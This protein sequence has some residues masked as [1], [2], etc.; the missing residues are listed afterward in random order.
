MTAP[1][2]IE[3]TNWSGAVITAPSGESFSTISAEWVV[4]TVTQVPIK[5]VTTS[6][7]AEWVGIDGYNSADVCQ[8]GVLETVQTSA[9][10][11]ITIT[12]EAFVEW[13]PGA[14]II[15]PASSFAVSPGNTI[16]VTVETSGKGA[17]TATVIL[18]DV[19]TGQTDDVSLT[20]PKGTSLQGNSAE[21]VVE[22]PEW[23]SGN[24]VSQPLLT[25]FL[26]S[27]VVFKDVGATYSNHSAASLSSAQ[28][29]SVWTDEVPGSHGYVEEASGSIQPKSDT[30]TVT[31]NDYWPAP[32]SGPV[33]GLVG[34]EG[35]VHS[36]TQWL[37]GGSGETLTGGSTADTFTFAPG[38]GKE[39]INNF[40]TAQNEIDPP[41]SL[42]AN[43]A[44][45]EA[46][47]HASGLNTV[48]T[49]DANDEITLS[50]VAAANLHAQNFHFVV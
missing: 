10:G 2:N 16:E 34:I 9:A 19:T 31:E 50:H 15:I 5:G 8:A 27:P 7:I 35:G 3:S 22:T 13:Y 29:I 38:F 1:T 42:F 21:V 18:D 45:V 17:T 20:A 46:D 24:Q 39:T 37:I 40:N 26:N 44:A 33:A 12:C 30:I 14:A 36:G 28:S 49:P 47:M 11:K 41:Q 32:S 48:I 6:D 43:F 23:I 25:D 4:P